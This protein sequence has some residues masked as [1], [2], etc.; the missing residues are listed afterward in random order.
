MKYQFSNLVFEGGGVKGIA[1]AGVLDELEKRGILQQTKNV[2]GASAGAV[3]ALLVGL[4]FKV[5]ELRDIITKMDFEKF[6]DYDKGFIGTIHDAFR[7]VTQYGLAPGD[8]FSNWISDLIQKQTGNRNVTFEEFE[9]LKES[10]N[11][12]S[13]YFVGSNMNTG[14]VEYYSHLTTPKMKISDAVRISMSF[15]FAFTPKKNQLGDLCVDGG[16]FDNY[17]VRIFDY[18]LSAAPG[19]KPGPKKVN[20][21]T[22]GIRLDSASEISKIH[23]I[24]VDKKELNNLLD[25]ALAV[26]GAML[27]VQTSVHLGSDDWN[28]TIYVD[29][30][31]VGTLD[32]SLSNTQKQALIESGRIGVEKYFN[33]YDNAAALQLAA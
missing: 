10:C 29:T 27:D 30:L 9:S 32:F 21:N 33:W 8:Y 6:M 24:H 18:D 19:T 26:V 7:V 14:I 1:Y 5:N 22:L 12:K 25:Y 23:G 3:S 17:P 20:S 28:R 11:L 4:G 2:A 13:V 31:N 16:V 15:P